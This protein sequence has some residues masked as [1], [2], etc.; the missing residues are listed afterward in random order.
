M[1]PRLG[2]RGAHHQ[3]VRPA[4][5]GNRVLRQD[6]HRGR[7]PRHGDH[8]R[9]APARHLRPGRRLQPLQAPR[10]GLGRRPGRRAR[11]RPTRTC[12]AH[13]DLLLQPGRFRARVP[14]ACSPR[15][16]ARRRSPRPGTA[17]ARL[18][19]MLGLEEQ[20][21]GYRIP[22]RR[23]ELE[24]AL[25]AR[26]ATCRRSTRGSAPTCTTTATGTARW[27]AGTS[28][29]GWRRCPASATRR[30]AGVAALAEL[31]SA[32]EGVRDHLDQ[33][34]FRVPLLVETATRRSPRWNGTASRPATCTTRRTTTTFPASPSP[35]PPPRPR[36]GGPATSCPSTRCTPT[37]RSGWSGICDRRTRRAPSG[38][39]PRHGRRPRRTPPDHRQGTAVR[40]LPAGLRDRVP[41][42]SA[43]VTASRRPRRPV[44]GD[45]A[46]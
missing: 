13:R 12:S 6:P 35:P 29:G 41:T 39:R 4:G 1:L 33:P 19:R 30:L 38:R 17:R 14:L 15:W 10:R 44:G 23:A 8:R 46:A 7:R 37:G 3:P 9:R 28:P 34:L 24:T 42:A 5:P 31:P 25:A 45:G 36:A 22:L 26:A 40:P 20:R 43:E 27:P 11:V 18:S 21:E 16:P 2:G 32:A